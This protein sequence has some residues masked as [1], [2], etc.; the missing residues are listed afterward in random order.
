VR[1]AVSA[2]VDEGI[3]PEVD[4]PGVVAVG[5]DTGGAESI[6]AEAGGGTWAGA[7]T[8]E[9]RRGDTRLLEDEATRAV[10]GAEGGASTW[11]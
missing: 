3:G 6:A 11:E 1:R 8:Q 4:T 5:A 7:E 10:L 2:R 9:S